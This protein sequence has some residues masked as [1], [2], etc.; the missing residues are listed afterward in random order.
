MDELENIIKNHRIEYAMAFRGVEADKTLAQKIREAGYHRHDA[1][2]KGVGMQEYC[3]CDPARENLSSFFFST[4]CKYCHLPF[5]PTPKAS[6]YCSCEETKDEFGGC[7]PDKTNTK[8]V[9]CGKTINPTP[10]KMTE[11]SRCGKILFPTPKRKQIEFTVD[12]VVNALLWQGYKEKGGSDVFRIL[13]RKDGQEIKVYYN[14]YD[15][16]AYI[17]VRESVEPEGV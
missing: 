10:K 14:D 7:V 16:P 4:Y 6:E 11:C 15:N 8:C 1:P 3:S 17:I 5:R 13:K 2:M 12:T 9:A